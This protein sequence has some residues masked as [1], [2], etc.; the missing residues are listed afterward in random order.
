MMKHR[1]INQNT[2]CLVLTGLLA[3]LF[4]D[5]NVATADLFLDFSSEVGIQSSVQVQSGSTI[6]VTAVFIPDSGGSPSRYGDKVGLDLNWGF[7]GDAATA[8]LMTPL[9]GGISGPIAGVPGFGSVVDMISASSVTAGSPLSPAGLGIG[10]A[11]ASF[12]VGGSGIT[13]TSDTSFGGISNR[14]PNPGTFELMSWQFQITGSTGDFVNFSPTGIF[15]LDGLPVSPNGEIFCD[16]TNGAGFS[17]SP[18]QVFG[19][20]VQVVPE[21]SPGLAIALCLL[22]TRRFRREN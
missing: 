5:Q 9:G 18:N 7:A 19:G 4:H 3:A 10:A 17:W 8:A 11:G 14:S 15:D 13:D 12:N 20:F 22:F 2:I 1:K 6:L 16:G 21:P